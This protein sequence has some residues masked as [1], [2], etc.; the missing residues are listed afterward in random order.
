V[1]RSALLVAAL[2]A[3]GCGDDAAAPDA[4]VER[5]V[6]VAGIG[7]ADDGRSAEVAFEVPPGT[8]SITLVVR[9]DQAA[10]YALA[11]LTTSDGIER[12][13][14]PPELDLPA[15]LARMYHDEQV[16]QL[17]G[18]MLQSIRLGLFT[19]VYPN[20]PGD[21]LPAGRTTVRLATSQPADAVELRVLMPAD[22]GAARLPL[23]IFA[24]SNSE[25]Y[26]PDEPARVPWLAQ[27]ETILFAGGVVLDVKRVINLPDTG[28]SVM[29][30]VHEPQE[31]PSSMS[32]EL[33]AI[34][35]G[36]VDNGALDV[37]VVD[38]LPAGIG[39]W[40]LGTPGP[41]LAGTYYSGVV[42]ANG[43]ATAVG[44]VAAHE[45][46]HFLGLQHV[47]NRGVSG[48][49]YPDQLDDTEPGQGNLMD[50]GVALSEGQAFV[51]RRSAL[52]R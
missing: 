16:G 39:G 20:R 44:R 13:G 4:G 14:L 30:E 37:F 35:A 12:V 32:A 21:P 1:R 18:A 28:L 45:I 7:F 24:V 27:A 2:A 9:G 49:L 19:H 36:L 29:T 31:P 11:A 8:R 10:L 15:E 43:A 42:V 25:A 22:D 23:N 34:A 26:W 3:V 38:R 5:D 33:A 40:S 48:A 47:V 46:A 41:P 17:P 50:D 6:V 51:L 52:L